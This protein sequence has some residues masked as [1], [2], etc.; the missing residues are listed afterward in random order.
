MESSGKNAVNGPNDPSPASDDQISQADGG[1]RLK[2]GMQAMKRLAGE[3]KDLTR[4]ELPAVAE[5]S[6]ESLSSLN[7]SMGGS[8][9]MG[10]QGFT[11]L[12]SIASTASTSAGTGK[13]V[14][15]TVGGAI[16]SGFALKAMLGNDG[17]EESTSD[18]SPA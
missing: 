10:E 17:S 11:E 13:K 8:I 3:A 1:G 15:G 7:S 18:S 4:A 12:G 14:A 16:G 5:S 9:K 2:A 6:R